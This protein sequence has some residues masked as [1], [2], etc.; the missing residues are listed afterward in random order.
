[1]EANERLAVGIA[2][3]FAIGLVVSLLARLKKR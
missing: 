2:V 1:M 3:A